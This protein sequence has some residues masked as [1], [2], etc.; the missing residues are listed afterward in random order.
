MSEVAST[1]KVGEL[2]DRLTGMFATACGGNLHVGYWPDPSAA[3]TLGEASEQMTT[4][5][6][7]KLGA[8][9]SQ[10]ILDVG[11]G[12]GKPARRLARE[13][14]AMVQGV[15]VSKHQ[16][17]I[18]NAAARAEKLS[19]QVR[20]QL[21]DAMRLPYEDNS[22]DGAWAI[23]SL[24][25]M[26]DRE[27]ALREIA[28]VLRPGGRLVIAEVAVCGEADSNAREILAQVY[29]LFEIT[30]LVHYDD[31]IPLVTKA[32]LTVSE[33][34]DV[35]DY[36]RPTYRLL[37]E[38]MA[39]ASNELPTGTGPSELAALA[40]CVYACAELPCTGYTFVVAVKP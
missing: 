38:A 9:T 31:F 18:A 13:T 16:V 34:L 20:F 40:G 6:I 29:R 39:A 10:H 22:F 3:T 25:H 30:S 33:Q 8:T 24:F 36:V 19:D 17:N 11:S 7:G 27:Q 23:E 26:P 32:G 21:A 1:D 14:G 37:A 2:Y 15:T 5:L 35:S 28:R 12:T 4:Q